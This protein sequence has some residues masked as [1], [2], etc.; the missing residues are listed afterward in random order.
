MGSIFKDKIVMAH[1]SGGCA[2]NDP[3]MT[4]WPGAFQVS[5]DT[6]GGW[7]ETAEPN[8]S[9]TQ[10]GVG[11]GDYVAPHF[12]LKSRML[13]IGG[14]IHAPTR[15]LVDQMFDLLVVNGFPPDL[16]IQLTRYEPIPKYVKCRLAGKIE[17]PQYTPQGMR[18]EATLLCPDP[19]KYD[20]V[21]T[22]SGS[23][24]V[25]GVSTGGMTLPLTLP[26]IFNVSANGSG[27]QI[28]VYNAGTVTSFPVIS[29]HGPLPTGWRVEN[30]TTGDIM[31]FNIG[32]G[33]SVDN[34]VIDTYNKTALLN[35]SPITGLLVG[36]WI[37]LAPK[38]NTLRLFGNFDP[39]AG[40]SVLGKSAWR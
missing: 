1:S 2:F 33:S 38:S 8:V 40:F 18:W 5:V 24:G 16:D 35:G 25:S 30:S 20:A 14:L 15:L 39:A 12:A 32:L 17:D 3:A 13:S 29:V 27:N 6:L 23:A 21:N 4:D 11:N 31:S 9:R 37:G 10:R 28:I 36:T 22:I 34:L 26:L 19:L 7:R